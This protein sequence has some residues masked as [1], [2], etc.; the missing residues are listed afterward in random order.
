MYAVIGEAALRLRVGNDETMQEQY[1]HLVSLAERPNII[2]QVLWPEDGIH[3]GITGMFFV[4]TFADA[5]PV[6]YV[7]IQN[8]AIYV[9]DR[10]RVQTYVASAENLRSVAL[11]PEASVALVKSLIFT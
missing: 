2:L 6:A 4:L 3:R 11:D 10:S 9:Q 7:E 1:R 5:E 8:D